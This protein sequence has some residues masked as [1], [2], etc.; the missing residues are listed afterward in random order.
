MMA[1]PITLLRLTWRPLTLLQVA[2]VVFFYIVLAAVRPLSDALQAV[3]YAT[4]T[5]Q[6][7]VAL[8]HAMILIP[9]MAGLMLGYYR[10]E[11][12]HTMMSWP[13]PAL[14]QGLVAG[15]AT[16]AMPLALSGSLLMLRN[17]DASLA[18][19][20]FAVAQHV[21]VLRPPFDRLRVL[22]LESL[23]R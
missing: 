1:S 18:L 12:Q 21:R 8:W 22:P 4:A 7:R 2:G 23:D 6:Q 19:A 11:L 9:G 10:L 16:V 3:W 15:A 14:R 20:A 5:P 13:V 17:A